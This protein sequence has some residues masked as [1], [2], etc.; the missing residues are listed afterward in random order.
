MKK[1]K[2]KKLVRDIM[3]MHKG[4]LKNMDNIESLDNYSEDDM[5]Q[6]DE[7][8]VVWDYDY[9][10]FK[11]QQENEATG[12]PHIAVSRS[13]L[14][15]K[16]VMA[17]DDLALQIIQAGSIKVT[18]GGQLFRYDAKQGCYC[19]EHSAEK[20]VTELLESTG[21]LAQLSVKDVKDLC[22]RVTWYSH[23]Q[24]V[25]DGFNSQM[26]LINTANGV[27]DVLSGQ[28]EG[29]SPKFLF[30]YSVNAQYIECEDAIY[31]PTFEKFCA[32]SL[33]PLHEQNSDVGE[34]TIR[35]KRQLLLEMVG[36]ACCDS[37]FGKCALFFKGEPDSGKSV[38]ANFITRIFDSNLI[39]NIPLHRLADRF[40]KAEL[41]GKKLNVAGEIQ[42][43]KLSEIATF[44]SITGND[45]ISAEFKG[46]D[47][48]SFTPRCKLLFAGNTLPGT[49]ES[50]A[51]KAFTNRLVL[52][53]F[54]H[55]V[56]KEKQDKELLD[57]LWMERNSI[58]TLAM[59]ALRGLHER[60]YQFSIP[61]ESREYIQSFSE[62]GNSLQAF[63]ADECI[64]ERGARVHNVELTEAYR[65]YC[66]RNGLEQ[67]NRQKLYDMLAGTPGIS[68]K[69]FR[70]DSENRW[71][72]I[73][74]RLI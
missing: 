70:I 41:F 27:L 1:N 11:D 40:N 73:G 50:D 60:N 21:H 33:A 56:P 31:C 25:A 19:W 29:Y 14:G 4:H 62:R 3:K 6:E 51:T 65:E 59:Q 58:F 2:T 66:E 74:I 15:G 17:L 32:T 39:S 55:S 64:L 37:N 52:L 30:T 22:I 48:F 43:K 61:D 5:D 34:E 49:F 38:M 42:G 57:K 67:Y 68:M 54:N 46:K 18:A 8:D 23:V 71:G 9:N 16:K 20:L 13:A 28:M 35:Q 36:Y 24:C 26:T 12:S 47:P 72:H 53:L 10:G 63:L 45:A 69:R 7:D 44:K